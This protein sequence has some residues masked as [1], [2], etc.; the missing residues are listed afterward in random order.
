MPSEMPSEVVF[1]ARVMQCL[2]RNCEVLGVNYSAIDRYQLCAQ[3]CK[4]VFCPP[5]P[6]P[7]FLPSTLLVC[8][9]A[10]A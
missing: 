4:L 1:F 6:P 8:P 3:T 7:S 9:S 2:R 5:H 10:R